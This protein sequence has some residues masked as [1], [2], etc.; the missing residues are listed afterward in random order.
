M[1]G[2]GPSSWCALCRPRLHACLDHANDFFTVCGWAAAARARPRDRRDRARPRGAA[3]AGAA[4]VLD[5]AVLSVARGRSALLR[6]F[7]LRRG[8]A[9]GGGV[10]LHAALYAD[11]ARNPSCPRR[12]LG[13]EPR[14]HRRQ[15]SRLA[16]RRG[17]RCLQPRHARR[18]RPGELS[19]GERALRRRICVQRASRGGFRDV[20]LGARFTIL[21]GYFDPFQLAVAIAL[22]VPT[23][24]PAAYTGTAVAA[25]RRR[26]SPEGTPIAWCGP[27]RSA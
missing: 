13:A 9:A 4:R 25:S 16:P 8:G 7:T 11:Y 5:C 14:G 26:S 2:S 3:G 23:G 19:V 10:P 1:V 17:L 12:D 20:R 6:A 24:N 27:R 21:G 15:S 22:L 18:R